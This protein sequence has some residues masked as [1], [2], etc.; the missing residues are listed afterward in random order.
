MKGREERDNWDIF[1]MRYEWGLRS[2]LKDAEI[3]YLLVLDCKEIRE[4]SRE[5][6]DRSW[7][8]ARSNGTR[9][10]LGDISFVRDF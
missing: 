2:I 1:L 10:D 8:Q 6:L 9:P 5:E 4:S 7:I 3:V